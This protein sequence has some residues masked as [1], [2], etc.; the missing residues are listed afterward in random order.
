VANFQLRALRKAARILGGEQRLREVLDAPPGA[1]S[2]WMQGAEPV[3]QAVF[4]SILDFLSDMESG[5]QP[6]SSGGETL[7]GRPR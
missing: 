1:F 6:F 7:P 2:R 4:L 3:P 5:V